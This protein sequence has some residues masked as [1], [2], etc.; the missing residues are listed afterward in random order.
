MK[1]RDKMCAICLD[2]MAIKSHLFYDIAKDE[3]IG[4]EEIREDV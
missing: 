2:E 1:D 4:F 3:I